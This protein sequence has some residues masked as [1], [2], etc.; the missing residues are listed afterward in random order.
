MSERIAASWSHRLAS[1]QLVPGLV[2]WVARSRS[3][4]ELCFLFFFLGEDGAWNVYALK[5]SIEGNQA[6]QRVGCCCPRGIPG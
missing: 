5:V 1:P 4:L 3:T 6:R 2:M